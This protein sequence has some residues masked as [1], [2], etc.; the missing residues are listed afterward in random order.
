MTNLHLT[1]AAAALAAAGTM[2]RPPSAQTPVRPAFEVASIKPNQSLQDG[3][4]FVIRA[5]VFRAVNVSVRSL[6]A[7][8]FGTGGRGL[9]NA[10]IVA[11]PAWLASDRFDIIAKAAPDA[12]QDL[13]QLPAFLV[14]LLE[15]RFK[16]K[17]HRETRELPIFALVVARTDGRRGPQFRRAAVDCLALSRGAR[18]GAP[19]PPPPPSDRPACGV[20]MGPG[21]LSAGGFSIENM[22]TML[23]T[24]VERLVVDRTG[25]TGTFDVDLQWTPG[26]L[27]GAP[28]SDD[29]A[30]IFTAVQ[31]QLG[32]KLESTKGPVDIVV[33]DQVEHPT[34]D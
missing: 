15:D 23:S 31:E 8:A 2:T 3:G 24:T 32:L 22:V 27:A 9:L 13:K 33:I 20:R 11:G 25:L 19:P 17:A 7:V 26:D 34:E 29:R 5:G 18:A 14:P 6:V 16:L 10:Q 12:L 1:L 30:S 28:P 21:K 4:T